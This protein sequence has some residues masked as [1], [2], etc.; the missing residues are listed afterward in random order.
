MMQQR[1][2]AADG[3]LG[4]NLDTVRRAIEGRRFVGTSSTR[5]TTSALDPYKPF[6][7]EVLAPHP[8]LRSPRIFDILRDR[9]YPGSLVVRISVRTCGRCRMQPQH[10]PSSRSGA[11]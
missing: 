7:A 8:R 1:H 4:L 6:V 9:G 11:S 2:L 5:V 3:Q 10:P